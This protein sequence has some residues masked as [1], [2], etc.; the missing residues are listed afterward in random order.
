MKSIRRLLDALHENLSA[1]EDEE[2][3]VK[4][5]HADLIRR[6]RALLKEFGEDV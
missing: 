1:W 2:E 4:E 3:S 5:E 6:T